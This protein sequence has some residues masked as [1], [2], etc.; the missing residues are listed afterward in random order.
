V[1]PSAAMGS[2]R[3]AALLVLILFAS[4]VASTGAC[5]GILGLGDDTLCGPAGAGGCGGASGGGDDAGADGP[6]AG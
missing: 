1:I 4:I 3:P 2:A 5:A 6:E